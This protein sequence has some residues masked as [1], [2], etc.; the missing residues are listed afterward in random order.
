[1]KTNESEPLMRCRNRRDD[2]KTGDRSIL[3]E[4][5]AGNLITA[6]AASGIEAA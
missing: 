4:K 2:V 6:L 5:S 1:M 3:R